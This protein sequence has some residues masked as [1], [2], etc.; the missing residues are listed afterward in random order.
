M[1]MMFTAENLA[2]PHIKPFEVFDLEN[3]KS[4]SI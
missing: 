3:D 4:R 2:T 1:C